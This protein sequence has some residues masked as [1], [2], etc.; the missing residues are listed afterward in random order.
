MGDDA[1]GP[2]LIDFLERKAPDARAA[3]QRVALQTSIPLETLHAPERLDDAQYGLVEEAV[4]RILGVEVIGE[5]N[6]EG[7]T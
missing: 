2:K 3:L 1:R 4:K 6:H 5:P 7:A